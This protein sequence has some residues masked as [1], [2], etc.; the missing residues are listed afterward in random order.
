LEHARRRDAPIRAELVGYGSSS[1]GYRFTD[2]HPQGAG[3]A[4]CMTAALRSAGISPEDVDYINA[5]GTS[6]P[7]NDVVETLSIKRAFGD[8]ATGTDQLHGNRSSDIWSP[9]PARRAIFCVS[10]QSQCVPPT[11]NHD[12]PS[13]LRL[14][15]AASSRP[16]RVRIALSNSFGFGGQNGAIVL[17]RWEEATA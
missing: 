5:H 7:Q 11:I 1:D 10:A 13:G 15:Y 8:A 16:R 12:R 6:T 3:P 4:R 2:I 9:P 14:D 17:K